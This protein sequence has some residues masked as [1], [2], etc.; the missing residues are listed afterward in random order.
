[1]V[2][3]GATLDHLAREFHLSV[4]DLDELG[5]GKKKGSQKHDERIG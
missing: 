3:T 1:M 5:A 2:H 4:K